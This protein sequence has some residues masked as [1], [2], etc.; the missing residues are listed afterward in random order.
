M[1]KKEIWAGL[2]LDFTVCHFEALLLAATCKNEPFRYKYS[3]VGDFFF[4]LN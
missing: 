4:S 3:T 2:R 1:T